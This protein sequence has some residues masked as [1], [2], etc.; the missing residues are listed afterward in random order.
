MEDEL[1]DRSEDQLA[2]S[3]P[4]Q[5]QVTGRPQALRDQARGINGM[6]RCDLLAIVYDTAER[7]LGGHAAIRRVGCLR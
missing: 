6:T 1:E 3:L 7:A 4:R 5:R 2:G